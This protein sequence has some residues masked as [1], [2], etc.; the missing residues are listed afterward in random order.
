[1]TTSPRG[2]LRAWRVEIFLFLAA[3]ASSLL[4]LWPYRH[5][6]EPL[7]RLWDSPSYLTIARTLYDVAPGNP[8]ADGRNPPF[9]VAHFPLYPL[10]IRAF[11]VIGYQPAVIVVSIL[12]GALAGIVFYRLARDVWK[13]QSPALLALT[14]LFLPPKWF[15]CR[16]VGGSESLY[17]LLVLLSVYAMERGR[18]ARASALGGLAA[19]T[20][21]SGILILPAYAVLL[22]IRKA[23]RR[24]L[25]WLALIPAGVAGYFAFCQV[26]FGSFLAPLE[27]NLDKVSSFLPF[28]NVPWLLGQSL[29]AHAEFHI[30]LAL[31]YALG[32]VRIRSIPV[33]FWYTAAQFVFYIFIH[34]EDWSRYFLAMAPFALIVGYRDLFQTKAFRWII[35]PASIPLSVIY[36]RG[37][38]ARNQCPPELYERVVTFLGLS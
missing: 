31:V 28:A 32:L 13:L 6:V 12:A 34:S 10:V 29:F 8:L 11:A 14:F 21:P 26:R 5:D 15:L 20:R 17:I 30:L 9:Y 36:A 2:L 22:I 18:V 27:P 23:P 3:V 37:V 24:Q 19:L 7:Y 16:S 25:L 4:V 33:I 38:I 1:M 35:L